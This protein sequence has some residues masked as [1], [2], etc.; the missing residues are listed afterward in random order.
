MDQAKINSQASKMLTPVLLLLIIQFVSALESLFRERFLLTSL[1]LP[2]LILL[3]LLRNF[4]KQ[5]GV[6]T[7]RAPLY[8]MLYVF[9][10]PFFYFYQ[11]F[12]S[13][14]YYFLMVLVSGVFYSFFLGA[15]SALFAVLAEKCEGHILHSE[16][17][18]VSRLLYRLPIGIFLLIWIVLKKNG[19]GL[20]SLILSGRWLLIGWFPVVISIAA[21]LPIMLGA[22]LALLIKKN[23]VEND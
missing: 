1:L 12:P 11:H 17:R 14:W 8:L 23:E 6:A 9:T 21:V 4:E 16:A 2:S 19:M 20:D 13:S 18:M 15:I 5:S 10:I 3:C 22:R 7:G